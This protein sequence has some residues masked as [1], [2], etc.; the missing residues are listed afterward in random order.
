MLDNYLS[1]LL[2]LI[3]TNNSGKLFGRAIMIPPRVKL[4]LEDVALLPS[5]VHLVQVDPPGL[6]GAKP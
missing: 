1:A 4:A 6:S 5:A 3:N 2:P